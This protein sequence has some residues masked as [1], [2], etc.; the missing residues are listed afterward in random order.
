M[1]HLVMLAI[2]G[3]GVDPVDVAHEQGKIG[4]ARMQHEVVVVAHQAIGE[5][6]GIKAGECLRHHVE[7]LVTIIIVHKDRLAPIAARG[8]VIHRAGEFDTKRACL[9]G[10]L[11]WEK[12]KGKT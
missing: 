5:D 7:K 1:P 4:S 11:H 10:K 12:A 8:D 9:E 3:L 6:L 2:E